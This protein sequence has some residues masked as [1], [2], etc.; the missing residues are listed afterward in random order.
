MLGREGMEVFCLLLFSIF[1]F[2]ILSFQL[3]YAD[4]WAIY[5]KIVVTIL[6]NR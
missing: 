5:L 6:I 3:L 1:K 2:P 4:L